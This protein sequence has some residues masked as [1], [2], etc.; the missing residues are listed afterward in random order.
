VVSGDR[1]I[2]IRTVSK[3]YLLRLL[4]LLIERK[5]DLSRSDDD[6]PYAIQPH[7]PFG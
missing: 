6:L 1:Q 4:S 2:V 3:P 5:A 7:C